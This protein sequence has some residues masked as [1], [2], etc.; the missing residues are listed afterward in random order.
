MQYKL[1]ELIAKFGG[2]LKGE[3]VTVT[4]IMPTDKALPGEITFFSDKKFAKE[5]PMCKASAIIMKEADLDKIDLPAI[6]S[7]DPYLY[8]AK[9]S[10]LFN[11]LPQLARGGSETSFVDVTATIGNNCAISQNVVIG[12]K[13]VIGN[14][15]QVYPNSVIGENVVIGDNVTIYPNVTIY[16]NVKIGNNCIIHSGVIIGADGFGYAPDNKKERHKIPQIG[17]VCIGSNVEIGANTTIDGGTF[18]PTTIENGVVI[19]NLVQIAHNVKIGAHS[20][21]AA[22]VG[23][24]GSSVIGKYCILAGSAGIA[25]HINICDHTVIGAYT[26]IG[27]SITTPDLYM[28]AYPFSNYKDYAKNAVHIRHLNEMQQRLKA[29]EKQFEQIQGD[30]NVHAKT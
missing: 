28:A 3:D 29:L 2:I 27:K 15:T 24:A 30:A 1:S 23:I 7:D 25:D 8:F 6:I 10:S 16:A 14:N 21:I 22:Q 11:P 13:S 20:V 4:S 9:V 18:G 26:G 17:G 5:L 19:D 12:K